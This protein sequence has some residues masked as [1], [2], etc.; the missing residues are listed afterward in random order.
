MEKPLIETNT[1]VNADAQQVWRT[2]TAG[3]SAMF[4]GADVDTDW[5][6]GSPISFTGEFKGKPYRDHG[7]IRT[8]DEGRELAF[9]HFSPMSGKPDVEENYNLVDIRL[10]PDGERTKVSVSQT[11]LG[12]ERPD[13]QTID[14]HRRNWDAMLGGLKQAA[15][16]RA[17]SDG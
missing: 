7:E 3:K 10:S 16:E 11:P 8:V 6:E 4:M 1:T 9:T 13:D 5:K 12:G 15:E 17:F 2:L 14:E